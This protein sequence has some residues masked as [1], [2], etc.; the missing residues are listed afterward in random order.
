MNSSDILEELRGTRLDP[1]FAVP[2]SDMMVSS[3]FGLL[4][5]FAE[6]QPQSIEMR[7]WRPSASA[8]R[9]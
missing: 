2:H 6:K 4:W 9:Q 7:S 1:Y 8:R 3:C 5:A